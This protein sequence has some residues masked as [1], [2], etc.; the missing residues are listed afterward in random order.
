MFIYCAHL[1]MPYKYIYIYISILY[2][3]IKLKIT[4]FGVTI[5]VIY[6]LQKFAL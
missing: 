6:S 5:I 1:V 2:V 4:V 3:F